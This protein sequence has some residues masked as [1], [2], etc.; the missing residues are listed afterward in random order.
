M[1]TVARQAHEASLVEDLIQ[2]GTLEI[3]HLRQPPTAGDWACGENHNRHV[4]RSEGK[5]FNL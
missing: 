2:D 3:E 4:S 1:S 5:T